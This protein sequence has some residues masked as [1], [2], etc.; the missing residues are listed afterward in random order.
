MVRKKVL[1]SSIKSQARRDAYRAFGSTIDRYFN[2]VEKTQNKISEKADNIRKF[3]RE[4][5]RLASLAN[6]RLQRLEKNQLTDSP[7]YQKYLR[8]GGQRFGVKGKDYNQ[9][10]SEVARLRRFINSETSTIRGINNNLKEMASNTGIKYNNLKE[11]RQKA[12]KFFELSSKV[13]QYLR[14]VD[15]MAS[16]IGYQKIWEAVNQYVETNEGALDSG[17]DNIDSM[18]K[19]VTDA[20]KNYESPTRIPGGGSYKLIDTPSNRK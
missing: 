4:T 5:S 9:V 6:K 3:R 19:A 18:I 10:Q 11:L 2:A 8:E 12:S 20:I 15:D 7:A 16:A 14:T 17:E 1:N 13:E